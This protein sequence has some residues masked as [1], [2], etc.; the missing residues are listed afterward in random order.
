MSDVLLT[1]ALALVGVA[2]LSIA[3][4]VLALRVRGDRVV[5]WT[6]FGVS[7]RVTPV[8]GAQPADSEIGG[9]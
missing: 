8:A 6:G 7:F 9:E 1:A 2:V 3:T 4:V 5:T